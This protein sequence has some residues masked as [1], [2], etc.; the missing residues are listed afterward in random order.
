[1]DARRGAQPNSKTEFRERGELHAP[2]VGLTLRDRANELLRKFDP[3]RLAQTVKEKRNV[4][5]ET[6]VGLNF[7]NFQDKVQA[8]AGGE[9]GGKLYK[10]Q[11]DKIHCV[12]S[13]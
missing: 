4:D 1:M 5:Q 12:V 3:L 13:T 10:E 11:L 9:D 2:G 7:L 8:S 6:H